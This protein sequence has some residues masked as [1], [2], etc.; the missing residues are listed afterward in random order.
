MPTLYRNGK[1][2]VIRH[3]KD[4]PFRLLEAVRKKC[5]TLLFGAK[6]EDYACACWLDRQS[7]VKFGVRNLVRRNGMSFF[8]EKI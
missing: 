6:K 5:Q 2:A 8:K 3:H 1:D 4:V 7:E